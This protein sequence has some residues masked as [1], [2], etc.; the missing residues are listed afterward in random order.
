VRH[1]YVYAAVSGQP[2]A[3]D[4]A[5]VP[6]L[7]NGA[8][9]RIVALDD[10]IALV[11]ADVPSEVYNADALEAKLTDLDWVSRCG[12]AHHAVADA[13]VEKHAVIPFRIFTLFS[14]EAKALATLRKAKPRI[15]RA[16]AR[17]KGRHEW[18]LRIS[19]PDPAR[20]L[21]PTARPDK[22]AAMTGAG[23][24]RAKADARREQ[25]ERNRRVAADVASVFETLR[26]LSD[27]VATR[28]IEPGTNLLLD[29]A[30]L[31]PKR[32]TAPL[33]K[34]LTAAA[35]PLLREGCAVSLTGPWPPY[36]FAALDTSDHNNG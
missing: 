36:S 22:A 24:L 23:F 32:R 14:S 5:S 9:P 26:G 30:F 35:A 18:V 25:T 19:K 28:A 13:L 10:E 20:R 4:V 27:D 12:A 15:A 3:R 33:Q 6:A 16:L 8:A 11:V 17:V 7:P 2:R 1:L 21:A 34:T 31:I 29:A